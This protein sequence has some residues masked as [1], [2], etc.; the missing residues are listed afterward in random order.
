MKRKCCCYLIRLVV[1]FR[2][3][4]PKKVS[5]EITLDMCMSSD[6]GDGKTFSIETT[7]YTELT[8]SGEANNDTISSGE[9]N[10]HTISIGEVNNHTISHH[11]LSPDDGRRSVFTP[12]SVPP[13]HSLLPADLVIKSEVLSDSELVDIEAINDTVKQYEIKNVQIFVVHETSNEKF[14]GYRCPTCCTVF[15][16]YDDFVRHFTTCKSR[17]A[18]NVHC[19]CCKESRS[20]NYRPTSFYACSECKTVLP[21]RAAAHTCSNI[22]TAQSSLSSKHSQSGQPSQSGQE[23]ESMETTSKENGSPK[24]TRRGSCRKRRS[25][26]SDTCL[27]KYGEVYGKLTKSSASPN[28]WVNDQ[29][30]ENLAEFVAVVPESNKHCF[31]CKRRVEGWGEA[32]RHIVSR[33]KHLVIDMDFS[34][35]HERVAEHNAKFEDFKPRLL[36]SAEVEDV[37]P[38]LAAK[39]VSFS[40]YSVDMGEQSVH[41]NTDQ[42]FNGLN[43]ARVK[44]SAQE[45][46]TACASYLQ[47]NLRQMLSRLGK[48]GGR[49]GSQE[50]VEGRELGVITIKQEQHDE[51]WDLNKEEDV[52]KSSADKVVNTEAE[53]DDSKQEGMQEVAAQEVPVQEVENI[54]EEQEVLNAEQEV[55]D[56]EHQVGVSKADF[57]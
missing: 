56:M 12:A 19:L 17:A 32:E 7:K 55:N 36:E 33:H 46:E 34:T 29:F 9:V 44:G 16:S 42:I 18:V 27:K 14:L 10:N 25:T 37:K 15:E 47:A 48:G 28:V 2:K 54:N 38:R 39:S 3:S 5:Q 6:D 57:L 51:Y 20:A 50:V 52:V 31:F 40:G 49:P 24:D 30:K 4:T 45:E 11:D 21:H 41:L 8:I 26:V 43:V 1:C 22:G 35:L 23:H 53:E 13:P